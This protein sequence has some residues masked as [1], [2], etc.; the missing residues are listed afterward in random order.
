VKNR[1]QNLPFKCNLQRYTAGAV[2]Q[3][4]A[5]GQGPVPVLHS[6]LAPPRTAGGEGAGGDDSHTEVTLGAPGACDWCPRL[7]VA[8]VAAS[9]AGLCTLESS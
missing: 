9:A 7:S 3:D 6:P 4:L 8:A 5:P 1:F 2:P